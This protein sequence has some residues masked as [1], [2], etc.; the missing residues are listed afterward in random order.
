MNDTAFHPPINVD[1]LEHRDGAWMC[2]PDGSDEMYDRSRG[3]VPML[4]AALAI[5]LPFLIAGVVLIA[6]FVIKG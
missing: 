5:V 1:A 6:R 3:N 2:S 4:A